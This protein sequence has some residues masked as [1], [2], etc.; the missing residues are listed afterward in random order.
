[1][2]RPADVHATERQLRPN[3]PTREL[4]LEVSRLHAAEPAV[5]RSILRTLMLFDND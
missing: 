1:M 3:F 5:D 2:P 4:A